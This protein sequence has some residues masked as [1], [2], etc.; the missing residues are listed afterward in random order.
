MILERP[1]DSVRF[2]IEAGT[3]SLRSV[4]T[5][6]NGICGADGTATRAN[7]IHEPIGCLLAPRWDR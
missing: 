7:G 3:A 6:R 5:A 2:G 1:C 4:L